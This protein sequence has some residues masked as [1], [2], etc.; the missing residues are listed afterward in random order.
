V[1]NHQIRCLRPLLIQDT[2]EF[3]QTFFMKKIALRKINIGGAHAWFQAAK[4]S[5]NN[6]QLQTNISQGDMWAFFKGF[7]DL[8]LPSK[9]GAGIP[10]TFMFD[11]ERIIK[12]RSDISDAINLDVCVRLLRDNIHSKNCRSETKIT[13]TL[14]TPPRSALEPKNPMPIS[15]TYSSTTKLPNLPVPAKFRK[16]TKA[17]HFPKAARHLN[18]ERNLDESIRIIDLESEDDESD[19]ESPPSTRRTSLSSRTSTSMTSPLSR[20]VELPVPPVDSKFRRAILAIVNDAS[21]NNRWQQS[22]PDIAL[23]LLR[24][25]PS[26]DDLSRLESQLNLHLCSPTSP[27][28]QTSESHILAELYPLLSEFAARYVSLTATQLFEVATSPRPLPYQAQVLRHG[29]SD[30][31]KQMAHIGILHWRVWAP[32][33]YLVD[34]DEAGHVT[35]ATDPESRTTGNAW[36][37]VA[38]NNRRPTPARRNSISESIPT[39]S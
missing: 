30:V 33:A 8:L 17:S 35:D 27:V 6:E 1:A 20:S 23:E 21:G 29:L 16:E 4:S 10:E 18:K 11:E 9:M 37:A 12:L 31:A 22:C 36:G 28:F 7:A 26:Q 13:T 25:T 19:T 34:P 14:S 2:V 32:L 15:E 39:G 38:E 5:F 24:S 3:E